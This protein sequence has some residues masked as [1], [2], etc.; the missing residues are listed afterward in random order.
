MTWLLAIPGR[1]KLWAV[2]IGAAAIA[3]ASIWLGGRKAG[4][5]AAKIETLQ[6]ED[7]A[8]DRINKVDTGVGLSDSDRVE[9]LRSYAE[10]HGN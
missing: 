8:H 2:A 7:K 1:L 10:R 4:K 9:R 3:L 6:N 5:T